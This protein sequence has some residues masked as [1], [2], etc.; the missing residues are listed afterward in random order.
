MEVRNA[1]VMFISKLVS[2]LDINYD[3]FFE[4]ILVH[5]DKAQNIHEVLIGTFLIIVL[6]WKSIAFVLQR[7]VIEGCGAGHFAWS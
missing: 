6:S 1:K 7:Y 5:D 2:S 3:Y 4:L